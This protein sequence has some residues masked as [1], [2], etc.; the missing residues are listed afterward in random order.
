L[1]AL[2]YGFA[3]GTTD[4]PGDFPF[5]EGTTNTTD[6]PFWGWV[7]SFL[8]K[9]SK[10]QI[11]CQDPK[12]ILLDVSIY[13]PIP[14]VDQILPLQIARIGQLYLIGV[15]GEFTT[16]SGRRLRDTVYQTL[17][18]N[19]ASTD[20]VV[21]IAGMVN[22]YSHYVATY[23]EYQLQRYEGAS[24]LFGPHTLA[25]Y[26]QEFS[27]LAAA[28][29]SGQSVPAGPDPP[30]M[31]NKTFTFLTE[32]QVDAVPTGVKFGS[33]QTDVQPSYQLGDT[34]S[35]VFWG[36]NP[37]NNFM[38]GSSYLTVE[39]QTSPN[40]WTIIDND[41]GWDTKV[42]WRADPALADSNLITITWDV[43]LDSSLS[44]QTYRISHSGYYKIFLGPTEPYSGYSSLFTIA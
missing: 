33:V 4:G 31:R 18:N 27:Y 23:E 44:G 37:R 25:A 21:V 5:E 7:T 43:P 11:A 40:E 32:N 1:A 30:D 3:G 9:P 6:N 12:P 26:Q 22:S 16:M 15:P 17:V 14:W 13:I 36:G 39:Q 2:G 19:G 20:I 24:T 35:V 41:G 28:L 42:Y 10:E 8:G 38:T 29:Q 34:V